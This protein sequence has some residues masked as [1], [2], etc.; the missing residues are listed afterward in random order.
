MECLETLR[1]SVI[2]YCVVLTKYSERVIYEWES[3]LITVLNAAQAKVKVL[4]DSESSNSS[5]SSCYAFSRWKG[6][7]SF[8]TL[9]LGH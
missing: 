3:L 1:D 6:R 9:S 7:Q 4:E 5:P 2:G 8:V